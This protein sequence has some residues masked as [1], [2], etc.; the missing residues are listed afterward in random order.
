MVTVRKVAGGKIFQRPNSLHNAI[1]TY[2]PETDRER[3]CSRREVIPMLNY[4]CCISS[5]QVDMSIINSIFAI[6]AIFLA[7]SD[8]SILATLSFGIIRLVILKWD[9]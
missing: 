6:R 3:A 8:L 9:M 7:C 1:S 2:K 5:T 4:L